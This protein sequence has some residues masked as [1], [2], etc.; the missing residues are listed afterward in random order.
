V[1]T[2]DCGRL[3]TTKA[4]VAWS[5]GKDSAV[6]L[7]RLQ[8]EPCLDVVGLLTT[9]TSGYDRISMQG[10]RRVLLEAQAE[11]LGL[12]V[13]PVWIP[14]RCSNQVY[15]TEMSRVVDTI[16]REG[17]Q[18]VAFGDVFL[19]DVR[20]YREKM[21]AP[22]GLQPLFPMW[23]E[24]TSALSRWVIAN[25]F[26]ATLVCVDPRALSPDFVGRAYD[27]ALL[28]EL[29]ASVDPCGE[30]GEFHTFV[31]QAPNFRRSIPITMGERVERD[32][33]FFADLLPAASVGHEG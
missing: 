23:G 31:H 16:Q 29:P 12:K 17:V 11:T 9:I 18:A 24:D 3:V 30:N 2:R 14:P 15:E 6:A 1:P 26:R 20:A 32:G 13:Y 19:E 10:V 27:E 21:L 7:W 25:D 5:A 8:R 22:T 4:V 33:F 28:A